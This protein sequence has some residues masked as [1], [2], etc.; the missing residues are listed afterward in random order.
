MDPGAGLD[1]VGKEK[2]SQPLPRIEPRLQQGS[3]AEKC[4]TCDLEVPGLNTE[5]GPAYPD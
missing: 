5:H 3:L 1:S 2:K 4:L